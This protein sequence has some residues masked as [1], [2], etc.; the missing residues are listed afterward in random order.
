MVGFLHLK[1]LHEE[2]NMISF[3]PARIPTPKGGFSG[4]AGTLL[5]AAYLNW[6]QSRK[7]V[8]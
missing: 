6:T 4:I 7:S 5:A 2:G 8:G 1:G 3:L